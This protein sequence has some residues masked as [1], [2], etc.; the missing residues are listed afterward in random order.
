M[1]EQ[2]PQQQTVS[3]ISG[4]GELSLYQYFTA[5]PLFAGFNDFAG[6][7]RKIFLAEY[8]SMSSALKNYLSSTETAVNISTVGLSY[9]LEDNQVYLM[10]AAIRELITGKIFIKDFPFNLSSKLGIDDI[11]AGEIANKIISQTFGPII[12]DVKRIQRNKFPDKIQQLQK[13]TAKPETLTQPAARPI[14]PRQSQTPAQQFITNDQRPTTYNKPPIPTA[15]VPTAEV[16]PQQPLQ[17]PQPPRLEVQLPNESADNRPPIRPQNIA[18][19]AQ[20]SLEEELEKVASVIDLR[21][22]P[23]NQNNNE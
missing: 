15:D 14:E 1:D 3:G 13:E 18:E 23:K 22:G 8:T 2:I 4:G 10:A 7:D 11:K 16:R 9:R 12:E 6:S 5:S 21:S 20:K 19:N 17:R